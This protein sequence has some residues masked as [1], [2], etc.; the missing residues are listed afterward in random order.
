MDISV[1]ATGGT[2]DKIYFDARSEYC[3]GTPQAG[4]ILGEANVALAC[5]VESLLRKDSL[6][7]DDADRERIRAAVAADP[8]PR[9]IVTHG[10][11]TMVQTAR[12]LH[13]IT[14]KTIVLTGAMQ[15]AGQRLSDAAFNVG[16]AVAA[17]QLLPPG[18]YIAMNGRVHD[19][20]T[21]RKNA[22]AA[23][24]ESTAPG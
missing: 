18:V 4:V 10:T 19:P 17:V 23:R 7:L 2:I 24:F 20:A 21:T 3:V 6:E 22:A 14:G 11:D 13:S 12:V 16:F 1:I 9:I 5:R 8:C 15:P